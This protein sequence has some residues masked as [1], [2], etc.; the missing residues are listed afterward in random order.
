MFVDY[1]LADRKINEVNINVVGRGK[2]SKECSK[3]VVVNV[4][5]YTFQQQAI[6]RIPYDEE[7][8][9]SSDKYAG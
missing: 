9:I 3:S 2:S 1:A 4:M 5:A 7:P 6:V 8:I